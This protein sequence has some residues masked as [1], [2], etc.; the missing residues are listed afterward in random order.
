MEK[1][2]KKILELISKNKFYLL[3]PAVLALVLFLALLFFGNNGSQ[4][5][6]TYQMF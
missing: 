4:T 2:Q 3:A 1:K 5:T 6:F